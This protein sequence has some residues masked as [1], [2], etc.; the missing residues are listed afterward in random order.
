MVEIVS[1][2]LIQDMHTCSFSLSSQLSLPPL[3][4]YIAAGFS[5]RCPLFMVHLGL[6]QCLCVAD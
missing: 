3:T 2:S 4:S 5:I 1:S 6:R